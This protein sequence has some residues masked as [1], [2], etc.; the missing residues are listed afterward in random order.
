MEK[1][2]LWIAHGT[3]R[4]DAEINLILFPYAGGSPSM[5]APWKKLFAENINMCP[6]LYP[7][8]EL[9]KAEE[10]PETI[11]EMARDFVEANLNLFN[12]KF[13]FFGHCTGV[14]IAYEV[15]LYL[16]KKYGLEPITII[17]S[18]SESP[19]YSVAQLIALDAGGNEISNEELVDKMIEYELVEATFK[20]NKNFID[21]YIPTYRNDLVMVSKYVYKKEDKFNC[22]IYVMEGDTDKTIRKEGV[23][24]WV[25]FTNSKTSFKKFSGG[26]F[27]LTDIKETMVNEI[28]DY[29]EESKSMEK[30]EMKIKNESEDAYYI[31]PKTGESYFP[32]IASQKDLIDIGLAGNA[33]AVPGGMSIIGN[34]DMKRLENAIQKL[35]DN[36]DAFRIEFFEKDGA[37][38]Q[39]VLK[40][41]KHEFKILETKGISKEERY[42]YAKNKAIEEMKRPVDIFKDEL[43]RVMV[44]EVERDEHFLAFIADHSIFDGGSM[45]NVINQF[46]DFYNNP[47]KEADNDNYYVEYVNELSDYLESQKAQEARKYWE[48]KLSRAVDIKLPK[49]E[50]GE[51]TESKDFL[52]NS[53][54]MERLEKLAKLHKTSV[55]NMLLLA[56]QLAVA[57]KFKTSNGLVTFTYANRIKDKLKNMIGPLVRTLANVCEINERDTFEDAIRSSLRQASRDIKYADVCRV[58]ARLYI[59]FHNFDMK[60]G[61]MDGLEVIPY[62]PEYNHEYDRICVNYWER[63]GK[64]ILITEFSRALISGKAIKS[65]MD[66]VEEVIKIIENNPGASIYDYV[67]GDKESCGLGCEGSRELKQIVKDAFEKALGEK[68]DDS[69]SFFEM[70]GDSLKASGLVESINES[71]GLDLLI[72]DIYEHETLEDFTQFCI[73]SKE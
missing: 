37:L 53:Y 58:G 61:N 3:N 36:N 62:V 39:R 60:I 47:Q 8:R 55:A 48:E 18:G 10:L 2:N 35:Y 49:P 50:A 51:D 34:I 46:F 70:G 66:E 29:L 28:T 44:F 63:E 22:P 30:E 26:H 17:A 16:R 14:L 1:N 33:L 42:E 27:Y 6:V 23:L 41:Y 59:T 38:Y 73:E 68:C 67:Y 24:D 45:P 69:D 5:F 54:N 32:V 72:S 64:V 52:I 56:F 13:A 65:M 57:N 7:A 19:K 20:E 71:F 25:N 12:K 40:K 11:G 43:F 9:R 31:S 4:E 15:A 21:Y